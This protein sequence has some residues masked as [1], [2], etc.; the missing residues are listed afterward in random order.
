MLPGFGNNV[1]RI[2]TGNSYNFLVWWSDTGSLWQF[3][4]SNFKTCEIRDNRKEF[5]PL[6]IANV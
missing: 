3:S 6:T 4:T 2:L 1:L 5:K